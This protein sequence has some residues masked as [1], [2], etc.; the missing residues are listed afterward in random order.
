MSCSAINSLEQDVSVGN[1]ACPKR[2]PGDMSVLNALSLEGLGPAP[3]PDISGKS[4][5]KADFSISGSRSKMSRPIHYLLRITRR[6]PS[7]AP[8]GWQIIR[9]LD[10]IE[11]ARS[12]K[13]FPTRVEALADSAR[14]AAPLALQGTF[15]HADETPEGKD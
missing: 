2:F 1:E 10:S 5:P 7:T 13:T 11:I 4:L 6:G 15:A 3:Y 8:F 9:Q 14:V 12:T